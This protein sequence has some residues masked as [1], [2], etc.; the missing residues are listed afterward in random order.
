MRG[1]HTHTHTHTHIYIYETRELPAV[2][3]RGWRD[4]RENLLR[5]DP[6]LLLFDAPFYPHKT[7]AKEE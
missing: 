6:V 2:V 5:K 1:T 3:N 7:E 4:L